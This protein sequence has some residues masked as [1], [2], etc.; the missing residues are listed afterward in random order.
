MKKKGTLRKRKKLEKYIK[1]DM[2]TWLAMM[3]T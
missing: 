3:K 2:V 1:V